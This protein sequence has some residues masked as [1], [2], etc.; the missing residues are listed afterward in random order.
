[1]LNREDYRN[2]VAESGHER[3]RHQFDLSVMSKAMAALYRSL[4]E[5]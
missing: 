5:A 2:K 1:L 3:W 4:L